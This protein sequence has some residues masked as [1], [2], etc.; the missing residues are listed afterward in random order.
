MTQHLETLKGILQKA[1]SVSVEGEDFNNSLHDAIYSC[2]FE[3]T[4]GLGEW[5][6]IWLSDDELT[7]SFDLNYQRGVQ[8]VADQWDRVLSE[9]NE[10]EGL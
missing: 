7:F 2:Q 9:S 6:K 1:L 3:T 4:T 10:G 8:F 5:I